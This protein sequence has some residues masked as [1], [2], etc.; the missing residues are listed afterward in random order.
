M[1]I[2]QPTPQTPVKHKPR[3]KPVKFSDWASI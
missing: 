1:D 2:K 3:P